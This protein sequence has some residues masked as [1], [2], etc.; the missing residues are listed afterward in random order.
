MIKFLKKNQLAIRRLL[1]CYRLI[2]PKLLGLCSKDLY[3]GPNVSLPWTNLKS[4]FLGKGISISKNSDITIK[5]LTKEKTAL[6]TIEKPLLYIG[7]NTT[8]GDECRIFCGGFIYIGKG[9]LISHNVFIS[10]SEHIFDTPIVSKSGIKFKNSVVIEE[11]CFIGRNATILPGTFL[12]KG[13]RVG[14]NAV[15]KGLFPSNSV[16]VNCLAKELKK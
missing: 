11:G 10:D 4:L 15:V 12:G 13:C 9:C 14:A 7:D 3:L 16:I 6:Y 5:Q 2:I 8:L 1:T